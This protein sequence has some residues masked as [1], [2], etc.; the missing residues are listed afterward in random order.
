LDAVK[1]DG[2]T[3][4]TLINE[5]SGFGF[6]KLMPEVAPMPLAGLPFWTSGMAWRLNTLPVAAYVK[7]WPMF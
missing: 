2:F 5:E 7:A 6:R 3:Q 1:P 4:R